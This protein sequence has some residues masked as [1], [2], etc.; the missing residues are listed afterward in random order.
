MIANEPLYLAL[1]VVPCLTTGTTGAGKS[2]SFECLAAAIRRRFVPLYGSSMLPEDVGGYPIPDHKEKLV[3]MMAASWVAD[4]MHGDG[5]LFCDEVTNVPVQTQAGFLSVMTERRV[6]DQRLPATTLIVG[7][8]NPPELCPN[9]VPLAPAM[10][11]RFA[12]FPWEVDWDNWFHGLR[13]GCNWQAPKFPV[14]PAHFTDNLPQYGALV[15]AFLRATPD[16]RE[17]VPSDDETMAFPTLRTWTYLVRCFAAA[18]AVGYAGSDIMFKKLALA[19]VGQAAGSEFVRYM[20]QLDLLDPESIL[21]GVTTYTYERRPDANICLLTGLVKGL[22]SE[23]SPDRWVNAAK[24]FI[25]IGREEIESFLMAFRPFFRP[26][27]EGGVRP[28]GWTPPPDVLTAL[29]G[30]V[31]Q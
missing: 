7:A 2:S 22:R 4:L 6:G 1:Q 31:Q 30:L 15:E 13:S 8:C 11:S 28:N 29:M 21:A 20:N 26:V 5:L 23:T 19:C 17:K 14:V 25:A 24:A 12:H 3:R 16:C 18:S 9:A 10:R 27:S